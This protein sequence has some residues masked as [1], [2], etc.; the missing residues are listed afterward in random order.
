MKKL[1]LRV[2]PTHAPKKKTDREF[3]KEESSKTEMTWSFDES[4]V[5]DSKEIATENNS[6]ANEEAGSGQ[7][8]FSTDGSEPEKAEENP[9]LEEKQ[10]DIAKSNKAEVVD[11]VSDKAEEDGKPRSNEQVT[12]PNHSNNKPNRGPHPHNQKK[13]NWQEKKKQR[14]KQRQ[15]FKKPRRLPYEETEAK[16]LELGDLL[17]NESLRS[18]EGISEL[19]EDFNSSDQKSIEL[20]SYSPFPCRN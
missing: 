15:K 7:L 10:D 18:E 13:Q 16:P 6:G 11:S 17:E 20:M 5:V 14:N 12:Q 3:K 9:Y 4:P 2:D 1:T 8:F 19:A